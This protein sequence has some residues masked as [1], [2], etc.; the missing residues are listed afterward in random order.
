MDWRAL[1]Q[2]QSGRGQ[3][4]LHAGWRPPRVGIP[5][6]RAPRVDGVITHH[7]RGALGCAFSSQCLPTLEKS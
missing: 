5:Y 6:L 4:E 7:R 1:F 2:L 3:G